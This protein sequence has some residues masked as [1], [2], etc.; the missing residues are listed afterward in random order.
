MNKKRFTLIGI[1]A[2]LALVFLMA[3]C[4]PAVP[5]DEAAQADTTTETGEVAAEPTLE[6]AAVDTSADPSVLPAVEQRQP[7]AVDAY[8]NTDSGLGYYDMTV[9]DGASPKDGDIVTTSYVMWLAGATEADAPQL[10]D[11]SEATGQPLTFVLGSGQVFP[12]WE[13][14]VA[15]MQIGGRRQLLIPPDLAFGAD[16]GGI[17][18]PDSTIIMQVELVT[19][20]EPPA[21]TAVDAADYTTTDTGL[22][23]IDLETGSGDL[24]VEDGDSV[25]VDFIIWLAEG[26]RYF[27]GSYQQGA[28]FDFR[29]GAG[30]VFPGWEEGMVG[31]QIGGKR[32]L[33]IPSALGLGE[34]GFG[35]SIPPNSDLLMEVVLNDIRKPIARTE[36]DPV[37]FTTTDSGLKYYD[38]VVGDGAT[39]QAGQTAVVHYTGW[40]EDGTQFDSSVERGAPLEFQVGQ[41]GVIAGWDEG[42]A[43]MQVGGKRQLVVPAELAYGAAGSGSTSP[44]NATLIFEVELLEVK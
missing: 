38:I 39:P 7:E 12:G 1:L 31:M 43:S 33:L 11:D 16:G 36:V 10:I 25:T 27:T 44:P 21:P 15:T 20:E 28:P 42:V 35:D 40:L 34:E 8:T 29:V 4:G 18:P 2:V 24:T 37:D 30:Q 13:E 19:V 32:Q 23:L 6:T 17:F 26:P 5:A 41:G 9:G 14:G 22:Q 3:A